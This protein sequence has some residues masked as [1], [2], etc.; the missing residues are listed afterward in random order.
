MKGG[1]LLKGEVLL[2]K[3]GVLLDKGGVLAQGVVLV[4]GLYLFLKFI[5]P[6]FTA[7]LPANLIFLYLTLAVA[8]I[9]IFATISGESTE[10]FFGP[11]VRF[12]SGEGQTGSMKLVRLLVL[13][14][15]PLLVGWQTYASAVPSDMPPAESRT[16]H[17][18]PPGEFVGLSNP[19]AN[20][21]ENVMMGKG[22][23]AAFCSPCHGA[24]FDGKGPAARGFDPPPANFV[25]PGTIAQLQESYLYWRIKKGGVGLPVEGMPW[26]SAMPRWELELPDEWVWK[27]IMG[28]YDGAH[29]KPRTW[30]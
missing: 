14:L 20:T 6:L 29:Q 21:P 4:V 11:I 8:G 18:A 26:K 30:E 2:K 5:L 28:E 16:I 13:V 10:E 15:F 9:V 25:D 12:L 23:F 1:L 17:P 22:L 7:P 19:I 3:V 27:I 24:N